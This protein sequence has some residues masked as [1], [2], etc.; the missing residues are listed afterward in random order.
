MGADDSI[1]VVYG[2][3]VWYVDHIQGGNYRNIIGSEHSFPTK[4]EALIYAASLSQK[5]WTE[6]GIRIYGPS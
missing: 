5:I 6:Y 2:N 4:S 3:G 1:A